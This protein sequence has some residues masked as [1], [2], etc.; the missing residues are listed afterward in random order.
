MCRARSREIGNSCGAS[1]NDDVRQNDKWFGEERATASI[2]TVLLLEEA[3][4]QWAASAKTAGHRG[5]VVMPV[6]LRRL[7]E[8]VLSAATARENVARA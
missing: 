5:V 4:T 2:P 6:K 7:R 3:Q 8:A 1:T